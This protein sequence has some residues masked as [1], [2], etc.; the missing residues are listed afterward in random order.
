MSSPDNIA[1]VKNAEQH[2]L[3]QQIQDVRPLGQKLFAIIQL[4]RV[5]GIVYAA[6]GGCVLVFPVSWPLVLLGW[7]ILWV[8]LPGNSVTL[9]FNLPFASKKVDYNDN[10]PGRKGFN[11]A[12]GIFY[13]GNDMETNEE[14]YLNFDTL[15]RHILCFGT[16]GAGKTETLASFGANFISTG[17]GL[18][19]ND[20][21]AAPKL[22]WQ[23]YTIARFFGRDDD[24]LTINYLTGNASE[25]ADPAMRLTN[26][27]AP[28]AFG[29]AESSSQLIISLMPQD[30]GGA[31]K[32]FSEAAVALI[33]SVMPALTELRDQGLLLIDPQVIRGYMEYGNCTRLM[34]NPNIS[35]EARQAIVAFIRSRSGYDDGKPPNKQSDEVRK[36]FG[37]AQSYFIRSLNALSSTY[38]HIYM[39]GAGEVDFR[40]V[41]LNDRILCTL[42]PSMQYSGEELANLGK[43]ILSAIRNAMA[44]GLG[45][46]I[47]GSRE[48]VLE[49]L[50]TATNRPSGVIN[51]EYAYMAVENFAITAAQGRGLNFSM[52]FG[53][54]DYAGMKRAGEQEAEQISANCRL[55]Y[56]M[57]L[58]DVG[59]TLELVKKL[60]GDI[61]VSLTQG[62]EDDKSLVGSYRDSLKSNIQKVEGIS[63]KMLRALDKG[64]GF[65]FYM[66]K[67]LLIR[68]F[69]HG[70]KDEDLVENFRIGRRMLVDFRPK[71]GPMVEALAQDAHSIRKDIKIW[72][73]HLEDGEVNDEILAT[74]RVFEKPLDKLRSSQS[75][76]ILNPAEQGLYFLGT[77]FE[78]DVETPIEN[79]SENDLSLVN[80]DN[81]QGS[82]LSSMGGSFGGG[83]ELTD[84][85]MQK[86]VDEV[87]DFFNGLAIDDDEVEA[88]PLISSSGD[89]MDGDDVESPQRDKMLANDSSSVDALEEGF[90]LRPPEGKVLFTPKEELT[91]ATG[92]ARIEKAGGASENSARDAGRTTVERVRK[93]TEYP[94]DPKPK[95]EDADK[96]RLKDL[97]EQFTEGDK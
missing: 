78:D 33:S 13:V 62:F 17:A 4:P 15:L 65:A 80:N 54:Q 11:K 45:Y 32:V 53:A 67:M 16:T 7:F 9:P 39:T 87:A 6:M 92:V 60:A 75:T 93:A 64:E 74:P 37:F 72:I 88:K 22:A 95:R 73:D 52:I 84:N 36:Q 96:E 61:Y 19:Y 18:I 3:Q 51:D 81:A 24:F 41:I 31:N 70:F 14:L 86:A 66:D 43:L 71:R 85:D 69:W 44:T 76:E 89:S 82:L 34:L 68:N 90:D 23:I 97:I 46:E 8:S 12:R 56:I 20:A 57:A 55:K 1:P 2:N 50:P 27:S 59:S 47:E 21:K 28:F 58:E 26:D 94:S 42:L 29:S 5:A 77:Y 83:D 10:T 35:Q 79:L 38:G 40:D 48:D 91:I 49:S 63:T 25:K 30:K